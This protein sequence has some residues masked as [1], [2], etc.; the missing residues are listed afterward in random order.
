MDLQ[1][2]EK[3]VLITGGAKGIGAAIAR[4]CAHEGAVP[5]FVDRDA[6]A[7]KQLQSELQSAGK[8]CGQICVDL[9]AAETVPLR[10]SAHSGI[11]AGSM[12]S[13]TTPAPMTVSASNTAAPKNTWPPC[14]AIF[15]ITTTWP[16]THCRR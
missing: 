16:T 3:V 12:F 4:A 8:V 6:E 5:V 10:S 11:L 14:I 7:G 9:Q 13:S 1:I 15:C 2:K